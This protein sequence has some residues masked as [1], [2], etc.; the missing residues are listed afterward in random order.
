[1]ATLKEYLFSSGILEYG[2]PGEI[3]EV[4]REFR[5]QYLYEKVRAFRAER[6]T[7]S[8]TFPL[9]DATTFEKNAAYHNM[10]LAAYIKACVYAYV[11]QGFIVPDNKQIQH[12]ELLLRRIGNNVNQIARTANSVEGDTKNAV[13]SIQNQVNELEAEL[14]QHL[15][16]PLNLEVVIRLE[17][18]RNPAF[19]HRL[20]Y[21]ILNFKPDDYQNAAP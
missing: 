1:M 9:Q 15:R 4:K 5:R 14:S 11:N 3:E 13:T 16:Q 17:L 6:R 21:L 7:V 19:L 2:T 20:R 18:Q 10:R 8:L 12:L